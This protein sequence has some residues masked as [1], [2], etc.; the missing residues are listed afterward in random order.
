MK[1]SQ[2]IIAP[3][4]L[5]LFAK[6]GLETDN[7]I[8]ELIMLSETHGVSELFNLEGITP[9][10]HDNDKNIIYFSVTVMPSLQQSQNAIEYIK[11]VFEN[12]FNYYPKYTEPL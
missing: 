4:Y 2:E 1:T 3:I 6:N 12:L 11:S 5:Q 9:S 7:V 10:P 8:T